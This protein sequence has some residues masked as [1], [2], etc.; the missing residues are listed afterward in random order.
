[1]GELLSLPDSPRSEWNLDE[2]DCREWVVRKMKGLGKDIQS[3]LVVHSTKRKK[4]GVVVK[5]V[6]SCR[7]DNMKTP[8]SK[9]STTLREL[10]VKKEEAARSLW[11]KLET[12]Y[13]RNFSENVYYFPS[14]SVGK[15]FVFNF[16]LT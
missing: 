9:F 14:S 7:G 1:M 2:Q 16:L 5:M 15:R 11:P 6:C 12:K 13:G 8:S 3:T 10:G 4:D